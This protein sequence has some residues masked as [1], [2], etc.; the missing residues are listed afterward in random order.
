MYENARYSGTRTYRERERKE[1]EKWE[2]RK[3]RK[4]V[5]VKKREIDRKREKDRMRETTADQ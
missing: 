4:C 5:C 2:I 1:R 3:E